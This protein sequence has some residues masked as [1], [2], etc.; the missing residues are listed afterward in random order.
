MNAPIMSTIYEGMTVIE[1]MQELLTES[2]S[3]AAIDHNGNLQDEVDDDTYCV[4]DITSEDRRIEQDNEMRVLVDIE[5][6]RNY[7]TE[8]N[9]WW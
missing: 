9:P 4:V 1:E 6:T 7:I 2:D 5:G 8:V 3:Y